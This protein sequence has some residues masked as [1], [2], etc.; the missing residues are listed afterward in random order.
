MTSPTA[1]EATFAPPGRPER[2]LVAAIVAVCVVCVGLWWSGA[3]GPHVSAAVR[4]VAAGKIDI[5]L[6]NDGRLPVEV[7]GIRIDDRQGPP[8]AV[9]AVTVDGRPLAAP[10][11]VAGGDVAWVQVSYIVDCDRP[12]GYGADPDIAVRV[13]APGGATQVRPVD[14]SSWYDA[15]TGGDRSVEP[16]PMLCPSVSPIGSLSPRPGP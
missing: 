7:R 3:V 15:R 13:K 4:S 11:R 8:V 6:R 5:Q 9:A 2:R 16:G 12:T 14:V 10:V 1:A